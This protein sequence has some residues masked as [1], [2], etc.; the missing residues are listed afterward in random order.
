MSKRLI[1]LVLCSVLMVALGGCRR[2]EIVNNLTNCSYKISLIVDE[3]GF[4]DNYQATMASQAIGK[5][6]IDRG[7]NV[8]C[9]K[10]VFAPS[11]G[12]YDQIIET[13]IYE[14]FDLLI[15]ANENFKTDIATAAKKNSNQ[16]F[17]TLGFSVDA[18]NVVSAEF[19]KKH[20]AYLVGLAS[21]LKAQEEQRFS[22]V[23]VEGSNNEKYQ[24]YYQGFQ[25]GVAAILPEAKIKKVKVHD[26]EESK[27]KAVLEE[28][29]FSQEPLVI[30][31]P[32]VETNEL[33]YQLTSQKNKTGK[34]TYLIA[35]D[36]SYLNKSLVDEEHSI[37]LTAIV[38]EYDVAVRIALNTL[39]DGTFHGGALNTLRLNILN[40]G[41]SIAVIPQVNL[42]E[43]Q[44]TVITEYIERIK[45]GDLN[46]D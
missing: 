36:L 11:A 1:K 13:T 38:K 18:P 35:L 7:W 22:F 17:L 21:A 8:E 44:Y 27:V 15:F 41:V 31:N 4:E 20:S 30:F 39:V 5:Y 14:G 23:F 28:E 2:G 6:F 40:D 19:S 33:M 37:L 34:P 3:R 45:S 42:S 25:M 9:A 46:I 43:Q 29:V 12:Q 24:E 10:Y 16:K 26:Y 32:V